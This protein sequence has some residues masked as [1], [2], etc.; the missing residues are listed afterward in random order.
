MRLQISDGII[1]ILSYPDTIVRPVHWEPF[2]NIW[3]LLGI[4]G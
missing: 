4:G 3:P 1:I 2:S